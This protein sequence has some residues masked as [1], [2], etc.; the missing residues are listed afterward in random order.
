MTK[1]HVFDTGSCCSHDYRVDKQQRHSHQEKRREEKLM[2]IIELNEEDSF[3]I[4]EKVNS[5]NQ[6]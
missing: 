2:T 4:K 6:T 1:T 5:N 3:R